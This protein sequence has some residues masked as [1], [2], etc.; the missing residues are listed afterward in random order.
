VNLFQ[1]I[2][3][4]KVDNNVNHLCSTRDYMYK[5][6]VNDEVMQCEKVNEKKCYTSQETV[7]NTY[8]VKISGLPRQ[9]K[10]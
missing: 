1:G 3:G 9:K 5:E 4:E 8:K 2:F 6:V 10:A 7:F